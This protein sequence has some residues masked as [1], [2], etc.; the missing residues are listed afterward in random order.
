TSVVVVV[1]DGQA[2]ATDTP[3]AAT[4]TAASALAERGAHVVVVDAGDNARGLTSDIVD[5]A[6]GERVPLDAL[7]ADR[8][9][10]A[11]GQARK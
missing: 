1:T 4:R 2:N 3:T 9:E 6:D 7:S 10:H 8:V 5:A 11:V